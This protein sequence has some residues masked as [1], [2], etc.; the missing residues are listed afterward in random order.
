MEEKEETFTPPGVS[1]LKL[2]VNTKKRIVEV[3][4]NYS[5]IR[6]LRKMRIKR[7]IYWFTISL[8]K[9][10]EDFSSICKSPTIQLTTRELFNSW[11]THTH[12][13]RV[14]KW[15][16]KAFTRGST[17]TPAPF[18]EKIFYPLTMASKV[19]SSIGKEGASVVEGGGGCHLHLDSTFL[20]RV[21]SK[22]IE[23]HW[24]RYDN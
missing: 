16:S 6:F 22:V 8:N 4:T 11:L 17:K 10:S 20:V 5:V 19:I 12:T 21:S 23:V 1:Y 3:L 14:P 18:A 24:Q 13:I 15:P 7:S 2:V 9:S